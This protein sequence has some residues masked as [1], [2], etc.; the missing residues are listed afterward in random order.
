LVDVD[1]VVAALLPAW[2]DRYNRDFNDSVKP[3]A[4]TGWDVRE[5]IKPEAAE[6]MYEYLDTPKLYDSVQPIE[7]AVEGVMILRARG[8][9][10]TFVTSAMNGHAGAKLRWLQKHGLLPA[11]KKVEAD[12]IECSDK[13]LIRGDVL[14]DDRPKNIDEF[15]GGTIL[16][17]QPH[18][19]SYSGREVLRACNWDDVLRHVEYYA[20]LK[21]NPPQQAPADIVVQ[22]RRCGTCKSIELN[23]KCGVCRSLHPARNEVAAE[24]AAIFGSSVIEQLDKLTASLDASSKPSNPKDIIGSNKLPLSVFPASAIALGAVGNFNGLVKYGRDNFRAVGIRAS[25]YV[26]AAMRHLL[27]WFEGQECDPDD[28]VPHLGAVLACVAIIVDARAAGKLTDDRKLEGGYHAL[29]RRADAA[30]QAAQGAARRQESISLHD[31]GQWQNL[32]RRRI[33]QR[34]A[35]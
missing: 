4:I 33:G 26:D 30:H 14:V 22:S 28:E 27:A 20:E 29:H 8:H 6:R 1:E 25:I 13:S 5:F 10:V 3:E 7:G 2:L 34:H 32:K 31:R 19:A 18:N 9:R 23:P 11:G 15:K 12:Y 17:A 35:A 16:F 24:R 21:A